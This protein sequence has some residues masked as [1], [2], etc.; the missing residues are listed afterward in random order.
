MRITVIGTGYLGATHAVCMA[1][2][3]HEV[4][5]VDVDE[6]KVEKLSAGHAPFY[7]PG[8]SELLQAGL[9]AE[10]LGFSTSFEQA[11]RF[12]NVHFLAVGTPQLPDSY[13]AD[14]RY[15]EQAVRS[16]VPHLEG[17]HVLVGKSTIPVGTARQ[18]QE[19]ADRLAAPNARVEVVWNPE[20]LREGHAVKDTIHPDRIVVGLSSRLPTDT[21]STINPLTTT[22]TRST[23]NPPSPMVQ[24]NSPQSTAERLLREIY[25]K[26]LSEGV[27]FLVTNVE[28]AELV[29]VSANAFLATKISFINAVSEVCE[30]TGADVTEVA[31]AMGLDPRIGPEFLGAGLGFG[32]GCLPKDIR[33]FMARAGELGVP[34][35]LTFLR[36]VDQINLRRRDRVVQLA[37]H[38]LGGRL[39]GS[40][41]A[42]LGCAFKPNSDDVRDSPALSVAGQLALRGATT[43]VLDPQAMD[44][45]RKVFPT[46]TYAPTLEAALHDADLVILA[47][48]WQ[49]FIDLDPVTAGALVRQKLLI[50]ARNVLNPAQWIQAGWR[51]KALGRP[52]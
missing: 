43:T 4:L 28:T 42:V 1:K 23:A 35:A 6:A 17:D 51:F 38:M 31:H 26:P 41:I 50:D 15:L 27:P 45:A 5:G 9:A 19:F 48:Q 36:E 52:F 46:L 49:E 10:T 12:A 29:K 14:T 13:A 11:A 39:A 21:R 25:Q 20:F 24:A 8:F 3:G 22:D 47:T 40:Q 33:G 37:E 34:E 7:E 16:L 44:N 18:L 30:A 2:L 32:G